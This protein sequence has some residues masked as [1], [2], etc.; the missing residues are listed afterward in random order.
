[1]VPAPMTTTSG[2]V[3][4]D[5]D[6]TRRR[7]LG[8]LAATSLG[9]AA[10]A[11]DDSKDRPTTTTRSAKAIKALHESLTAEQRQA[12]CFSWDHRGASGL[13]L[14]LHVTNNW[15]VSKRNIKSF[16]RDQQALI[17]EIIQ[18]VL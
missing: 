9:A 14:R 6:I 18:S 11:A 8:G 4:I 1:M 13:P 10:W 16:S 12:I 17:G 2:K 15:A 5:A 3:D 7:L